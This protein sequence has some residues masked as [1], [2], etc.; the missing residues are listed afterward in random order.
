MRKFK[1][2]WLR[3]LDAMTPPLDKAVLAEPIPECE[4]KQL[5]FYIRFQKPAVAVLCLLIISVSVL[6]LLPKAPPADEFVTSAVML[7]INPKAVFVTGEDGTVTEVVSLNSD[8]D[9]ILSDTGRRG[10]LI[11]K[12]LSDAMV[13]FLDYSARAG[14]INLDEPDAIR[15][16][17]TADATEALVSD[18]AAALRS[19]FSENNIKALVAD[20]F[21]SVS[22]FAARLGA[23][24]VATAEALRG[25]LREQ[26]KLF[27]ERE[28]AGKSEGEIKANYESSVLEGYLKSELTDKIDRYVTDTVELTEINL[29]IIAEAHVDYFTAKELIGH[30]ILS[31]SAEAVELIEKMDSRLLAYAEKYGTEIESS[32]QLAAAAL[33]VCDLLAEFLGA[34]AEGVV[35]ALEKIPAVIAPDEGLSELLLSIPTTAEEYAE[36]VKGASVRIFDKLTLD[37]SESFSQVRETVDYAALEEDIIESYGSVEAFYEYISAA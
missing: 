22:D 26:T 30:P 3:E 15:L 18:T 29:E 23:E 20:G 25:Y 17:A 21:L 33:G 14:Y 13:S 28:M 9:L 37:F 7:E 2:R 12:P 5:P 31:P 8:A 36:R 16:S 19:Y 27:C 6:F 32:E 10:E 11:G 1:K 4:K 35:G 34:W 24:E